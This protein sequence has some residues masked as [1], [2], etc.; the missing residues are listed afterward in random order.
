MSDLTIN[1]I[2]FMIFLLV[3]VGLR[4]YFDRRDS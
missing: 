4:L 3:L 2:A 1:N